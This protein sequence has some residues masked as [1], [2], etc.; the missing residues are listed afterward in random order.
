MKE[1]LE[2]IRDKIWLVNSIAHFWKHL[3]KQ[4][5]TFMKFFMIWY[6]KL[7]VVILNLVD[8]LVLQRNAV[9]RSLLLIRIFFISLILKLLQ[10]ITQNYLY[11]RV[12]GAC[13]MIFYCVYLY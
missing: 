7:I 4:K 12:P 13:K 5:S 1:L 2:K 8:A 3:R 6:G 10:L 9:V 11:P